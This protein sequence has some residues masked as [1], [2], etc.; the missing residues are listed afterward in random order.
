MFFYKYFF[1]LFLITGNQSEKR[2]Y[3][4]YFENGNLKSEG[5]MLNSQKTDYWYYYFENGNVKGKGSYETNKKDG[6]WFY[7]TVNNKLESQGHYKNGKRVD[8]WVVQK[9]NDVVEKVKFV[10]DV[11]EGYSLLYKNGR[12]FKAQHYENNV[13]TGAWT[14][15]A[16]FKKDNP[17][18]RF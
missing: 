14:S 15:V 5:W 16:T 2:Y 12:L 3:K 4:E 13:L 6:Y 17:N 7:Y 11:K 8:W 18:A 1:I 9:E 10:N